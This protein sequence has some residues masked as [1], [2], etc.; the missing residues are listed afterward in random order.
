MAEP[1]ADEVRAW[2]TTRLDLITQ[3]LRRARTIGKTADE[4]DAAVWLLGSVQACSEIE[5]A[6]RDIVHLLTS[7]AIRDQ[8]TSA[9][10]VAR[11]SG[12]TVAAATARVGGRAAARASREV[13]PPSSPR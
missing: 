13:W 10:S 9:T 5:N 12:V 1:A 3:Q 2:V 11:A 4:T 7:Y 8:V 6:A